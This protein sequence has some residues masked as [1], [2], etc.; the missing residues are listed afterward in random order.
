ME[1]RSF[2][3]ALVL[4]HSQVLRTKQGIINV[5]S[6][7]LQSSSTNADDE[8]L[9]RALLQSSGKHSHLVC[10]SNA[11]NCPTT[12]LNKNR[13]MSWMFFDKNFPAGP[14]TTRDMCVMAGDNLLHMHELLVSNPFRLK[15]KVVL[16]FPRDVWGSPLAMEKVFSTAWDVGILD[17]FIV[18]PGSICG[19]YTYRPIHEHS[20]RSSPDLT[21]VLITSWRDSAAPTDNSNVTYFPDRQI[22]N[23]H[24]YEVQLLVKSEVLI[25]WTPILDFLRVAMN[26]S[27]NITLT[28]VH[29]DYSRLRASQFQVTPLLVLEAMAVHC[30]LP[31]Y[32]VFEE[33]VF[34]VPRVPTYSSQWLRLFNELSEYVWYAL[35]VTVVMTACMLYFLIRGNR[36]FVFVIMFVVQPLL[37][38][39]QKG[40]FLRWRAR[41]F[42]VNWLLFSFIVQS[43]YVCS[44]LSELIAPSTADALNSLDDLL[45]TV[46][47]IHVQ[48][49]VDSTHL[50]FKSLQTEALMSK[51]Q[52]YRGRDGD[53][54]GMVQK[55]R[56]DIAYIVPRYLFSALF[57]NMPYRILPGVSINAA[58]M[59]FRLNRPSPHG[60][61][62]ELAFMRAMGA[63]AVDKVWR[64]LRISEMSYITHKDGGGDT[65]LDPHRP[66]FLP[67]KPRGVLVVTWCVGC[68][69][70]LFSFVVEVILN[71]RVEI[72]SSSVPEETGR[73]TYR[74]NCP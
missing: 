10:S 7:M 11:T 21:P 52:Q 2:I 55:N 22:S 59:P 33:N 6:S 70:A 72:L 51:I 47:P 36:D 64:N 16:V 46:L 9:V 18:L 54:E 57:L 35:L 56:R 74:R 24:L 48:L 5:L 45:E 19:V 68:I 38:A 63:G 12:I 67:F 58:T 71:C 13:A 73:V 14:F 61:F 15:E 62:F 60:R 26:A 44:S 4:F 27:F 42:F 66:H 65:I 34:A 49:F 1:L 29:P 31:A 8:C 40:D 3:L 25:A 69:L 30:F 41:I 39:P 43:S 17:V 53:F 28:D 32:V 50:P 37:V 23:L 20:S